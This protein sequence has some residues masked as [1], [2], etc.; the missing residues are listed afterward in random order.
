M[1][2]KIGWGKAKEVTIQGTGSVRLK[3]TDS[4]RIIILHNCVYMPEMG[5]NLI[6]QGKL[7]GLYSLFDDTSV[8]IYQKG[9]N[10]TLGSLLTT[11]SMLG[12]LY[13]LPVIVEINPAKK[14]I[15]RVSKVVNNINQLL[16]QRFGHIGIK[17]VKALRYSTTSSLFNKDISKFQNT[18]QDSVIKNKIA[19]YNKNSLRELLENKEE[20]T[21]PCTV[22]LKAN[23]RQCIN[24][25]SHTP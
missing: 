6:S 3:F 18:E 19:E 13:K 16:H 9:E 25:K 4:K 15:L 24:K 22:C 23:I 1:K 11:G 17:A 10:N 2:T 14:Q 7:K 12:K 8:S 5:I 21:S 20:D